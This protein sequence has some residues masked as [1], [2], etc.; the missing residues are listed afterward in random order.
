V[1]SAILAEPRPQEPAA[2][3]KRVEPAFKPAEILKRRVLQV[4]PAVMREQ[5]VD[6]WIVFTRENARDPIAEDIGGGAV[7]A[8]AA[9]VFHLDSTGA[10]RRTAI[11]ASYDV[12]QPSRSGVYERVIAYQQEGVKPHLVKLLGEAAPK[13]IAINY[14]RDEPL[15]DGLTS[16]MRDYLAE[17][18]GA[19]LAG[20]FV[21]AENIIVSL[22]SRKLPEEIEFYQRAVEAT[23]QI[24]VS[25]LSSRVI[26]PDATTKRD[27]E[28]FI[29]TRA[30]SLGAEVVFI[31][32]G[33]GPGTI[34]RRGD[35]VRIDVGLDWGGYKTDIQRTAYVLREEESEPPG[36]IKRMWD[37]A[38]RAN[39]AAVLAMSPGATGLGIDTAARKTIALA[40]YRDY[41]HATGHPIGFD[42]HDAGPILGPDWKE[43][44]GAKVLRKLE[45]GQTFAV[46]PA[47]I[48]TAHGSRNEIEIGLEENVVI[49]TAGARYLGMPQVAIIVIR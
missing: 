17:V 40:G 24:C 26:I 28:A 38:L 22:R 48:S 32:V 36:Q 20:R 49:E 41:A 3:A 35:L 44:Y 4:L 29:R 14:S 19:D 1:W 47:V 23:Q 16:G 15:A 46:E 45:V 27:I 11:V 2:Q 39:R 31:T 42:L 30:R 8:R 37:T 18:V 12:Q 21:S 10:L 33:A 5:G 7:V 9:F 34:I 25:T 43:R 13:R 6:C